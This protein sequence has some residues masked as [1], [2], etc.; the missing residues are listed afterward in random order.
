M[1]KCDNL[2]PLEL[3][4]FDQKS[5]QL[6][7]TTPIIICVPNLSGNLLTESFPTPLIFKFCS[8]IENFEGKEE[9]MMSL[10]HKSCMLITPKT[11]FIVDAIIEKFFCEFF[12][13][14]S[15]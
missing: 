14:S 1:S 10:C 3:V 8:F 13:L 6:K 2:V 12:K 7:N 15:N 5:F 9:K 4:K 11:S